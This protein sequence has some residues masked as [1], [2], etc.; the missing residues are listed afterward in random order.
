MTAPGDQTPN[1]P[2]ANAPAFGSDGP[3]PGAPAAPEP[4]SRVGRIVPVIFIVGALVAAI[5]ITIGTGAIALPGSGSAN[6]SAQQTADV[7]Q[8]AAN[9][10]WA[11]ATCSTVLGWK[12]EIQ[13]DVHGLTLSLSAIPRVQDAIGATTRV[14]NSIKKLG[15]PP[16]LR[17][18]EGRAELDQLRSDVRSHVQSIESAAASV[19]GGN[20]AAIGTLVSDLRTAPSMGDRIVGHLR[21]V[22]SD[23]GVSLASTPSCRALVGVKL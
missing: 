18:A 11:S 2:D 22:A 10:Q 21:V 16:A 13:R 7:R 1:S 23:L 5:A 4:G 9:R 19:A 14:A 17:S 6:L 15:L 20:L 3:S 8:L 12:N